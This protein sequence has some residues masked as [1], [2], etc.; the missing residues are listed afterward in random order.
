MQSFTP[1]WWLKGISEK[2]LLKDGDVLFAAKGPKILQ[3][4]LKTTTNLLLLPL[5]FL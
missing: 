4:F 2:H 1:I 5:P 3:P